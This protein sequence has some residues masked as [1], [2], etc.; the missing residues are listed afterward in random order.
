MATAKQRWVPRPR[1]YAA[2]VAQAN[3]AFLSAP[4]ALSHPLLPAPTPAAA[5]LIAS[6]RA[7]PFPS[8][9]SPPAHEKEQVEEETVVFD[10]LLATQP[11]EELGSRPAAVPIRAVGGGTP[12]AV[13]E[14]TR[15]TAVGGLPPEGDLSGLDWER[16]GRD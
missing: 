5:A 4:F 16:L 7:L 6:S 13:E 3:S 1:A 10:P 12:A 11:E 2:E 15:R 14:P 9:S 8:N